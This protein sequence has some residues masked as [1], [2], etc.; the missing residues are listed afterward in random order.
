MLKSHG[1]G[2][3]QNAKTEASTLTAKAWTFKAKVSTLT[4][5]AWTFKA[6]VYKHT[7]KA[8]IKIRNTI[9]LTVSK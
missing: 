1:C 5:K 8:E 9:H 7:V 4:A 6:K 2:Q 3:C